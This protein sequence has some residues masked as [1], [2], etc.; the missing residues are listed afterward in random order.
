MKIA[1]IGT[2]NIGSAYAKALS[3]TGHEVVVG[4]RDPAKAATLAKELGGNVEGGGIA[5]AIKLADVVFLT[6]PFPAITGVLASIA[7]LSGKI[8]IDVSNPVSADYQ[9]LLV[10][11]DT[12]AAEQIQATAPSAHVVKGFNTIFAGLVPKAASKAKELQVFI[13][14]N[15]SSATAVVRLLAQELGF[16]PVDAGPLRN[17]RYLEPI[18]MM[19]IQFGF[20]L[21]EGPTTAPAWIRV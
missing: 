15:D 2:G 20:F 14:G 5:A 18:G 6:I 10:G 9:Q 21:G 13:A 19:N 12:S 11:R 17:S 7:D 3:V 8:L 16:I 4:H 1:V